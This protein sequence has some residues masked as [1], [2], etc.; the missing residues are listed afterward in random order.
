LCNRKNWYFL[1]KKSKFQKLLTQEEN[2]RSLESWSLNMQMK[3]N[4]LTLAQKKM[5]SIS[6]LLVNE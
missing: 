1:W 6:K 4:H 5:H 2:S 3:I